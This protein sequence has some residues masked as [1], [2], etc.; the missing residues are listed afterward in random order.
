MKNKIKKFMLNELEYDYNF[1]GE[2]YSITINGALCETD[3]STFMIYNEKTFPIT[4]DD[5]FIFLI[6]KKEDILKYTFVDN[7]KLMNCISLSKNIDV[8]SLTDICLLS[9]SVNELSLEYSIPNTLVKKVK[10][11]YR[12]HILTELYKKYRER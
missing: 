2:I 4:M 1:N 8:K 9:K 10:Y 11:K 3:M 12:Q 6:R 5:F 7:S